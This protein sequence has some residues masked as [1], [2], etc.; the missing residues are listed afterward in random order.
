MRLDG[1]H[2]DI[3][4]QRIAVRHDILGGARRDIDRLTAEAQ[5]DGRTRRRCIRE[6]ET[7]DG[8]NG[9]AFAGG[10]QVQLDDQ[11]AVWLEP[12]L[13]ARR[14]SV[15]RLAGCPAKQLTFRIAGVAL[16]AAL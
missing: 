9:F 8:L 1:E 7:D 3:D 13:R 4:R 12:P 16:H 15:R 14:Y 10:L 5:T 2:F 6:E 11:I